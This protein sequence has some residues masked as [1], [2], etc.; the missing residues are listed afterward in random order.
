MSTQ[1]TCTQCG[2]ALL[3]E[4]LSLLC[5]KC[6]RLADAEK[7]TLD[8]HLQATLDPSGLSI[9]RVSQTPESIGDYE[10]LAEIARGGM[11]VVY[12]ARHKHLNRMV[13]LKMILQ[14]QFA[15]E[16]D[17]RRFYLEA[18]AAANLDHPGIVPVYEVGQHGGH[19]FF[20][21]KL[22]EGGSLAQHLAEFRKDT[23]K[24]VRCISQVAQAV[25]HAHLRGIM[26]RDLKPANILIDEN[27]NPLVSDL[28]LAKKI[29][30]KSDLT[31]TGTVVGTPAYMS[32]EQAN[33]DDGI[34]IAADIY[35]LG[36]ILYEALTGRPPHQGD[37][38]LKTLLKV[39]E[40][41]VDLPRTIDKN[42]D[43]TLELICMKCLERLP[44]DRYGSAEALASDLENWLQGKKVSVRPASIG[45][46]IS[47]L[48][49]SNLRSALGAAVLSIASGL[50][51][52]FGLAAAIESNSFGRGRRFDL[53]SLN[54]S[55][56]SAAYPIPFLAQSPKFVISIGL[57]L[58][59]L[60]FGLLGAIL[61][62][63]LQPKNIRE[64]IALTFI[65]GLFMTLTMY[66]SGIGDILIGVDVQFRQANELRILTDA[67]LS[68]QLEASKGLEPFYSKLPELR[69][70]SAQKQ[71]EL[72]AKHLTV[73]NMFTLGRLRKATLSI[74]FLMCF[75]CCVANG[76]HVFRLRDAKLRSISQVFLYLEFT[77]V[78]F[79]VLAM[80]I[81]INIAFFGVTN[82]GGHTVALTWRLLAG[83]FTAVV[84]L[85]PSYLHWRWYWRLVFYPMAF[86]LLLLL[87]VQ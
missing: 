26:H 15:S 77:S 51:I 83:L 40:G 63:I 43:R 22:I 68:G 14:G 10:L 58:A 50:L 12:R 44:S 59:I 54:E 52:S 67:S 16:N 65:A 64:A 85:L 47:D 23:R 38:P 57:I 1:K 75:G 87:I 21:M 2:T 60:I 8:P 81:V 42:V 9:Q 30:A 56:P 3:D 41:N 71:S 31:G 5:S 84:M 49:F 82:T 13:A 55:L 69:T 35:S 45:A 19:H 25:H 53:Y 27:Q 37:S 36:A 76:I 78:C 4:G 7:L 17:V 46:T 62:K 73:T 33:G 11:G 48:L 79:L 66:A 72:I 39:I 29:Q 18:E 70:M 61:D 32:P 34:T 20:S 80:S 28:G 74:T 86:G 6:S 24:V